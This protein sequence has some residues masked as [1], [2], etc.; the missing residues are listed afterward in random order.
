MTYYELYEF[1]QELRRIVHDIELIRQRYGYLT[2]ED[3]D[4]VDMICE[5]LMSVVA[6]MRKATR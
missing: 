1:E 2:I 6:R 3:Y 4:M 5:Q